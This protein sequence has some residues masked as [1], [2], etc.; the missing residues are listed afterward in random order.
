MIKIVTSPSFVILLPVAAILAAPG[1]GSTVARLAASAV[2][3]LGAKVI[4]IDVDLTA[5]TSTLTW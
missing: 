4:G 5:W 1:T 3:L 2:L